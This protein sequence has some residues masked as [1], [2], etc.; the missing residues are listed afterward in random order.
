MGFA[1]PS[2]KAMGAPFGQW[3]IFGGGLPPPT[4]V[5]GRRDHGVFL[6]SNHP[7]IASAKTPLAS[8]VWWH[9]S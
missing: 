4:K 2:R 1:F 6:L 3:E 5:G 8:G 7:K 9:W